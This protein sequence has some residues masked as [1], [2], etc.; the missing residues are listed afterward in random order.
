M[1][2]T[3]RRVQY[4]GRTDDSRHVF[5]NLDYPADAPRY[6]RYDARDV[7]AHPDTYCNSGSSSP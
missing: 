3:R 5:E 2:D 4:L 1:H 7:L 6:I